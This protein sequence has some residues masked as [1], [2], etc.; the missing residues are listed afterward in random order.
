[1]FDAVVVGAGF[2]GLY[3]IKRLRDA[4][5]SVCA[6]EAA[7]GVGGTWYWNAYPGARCDVESFDYCYSFSRELEEEWD[8]SERYPSQG[9]LLRYLNHVADRFDLRA[10]SLSQ[11]VGTLAGGNQQKVVIGK[12][13]A[14]GPKII[15]L[16]EPSKGI[17]I[18]SKAAVHA[19]ISEL[20]AQGL[21]VVM[22]SSELPEI[23]GMSDRVLVMREGRQAG[24]YDRDGL[25]AETLVRA[26]TGNMEV[27]A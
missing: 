14:T 24:I 19:F 11:P 26:A 18:G 4:G 5:F 16:D 20:A 15:I 3:L 10:A 9:E 8:W 17:D 13:L 6:V 23:L 21:A 2:S 25:S 7:P 22:I 12:W 1:M 27:A